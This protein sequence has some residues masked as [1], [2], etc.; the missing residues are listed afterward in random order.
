MSGWLCQWAP[1]Q[2]KGGSPRG[3]LCSSAR[4]LTFTLLI[5]SGAKAAGTTRVLWGSGTLCFHLVDKTGTGNRELLPGKSASWL[6]AGVQ[7]HPC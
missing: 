4:R 6:P 7:H 1:L 5:A 2:G 3:L